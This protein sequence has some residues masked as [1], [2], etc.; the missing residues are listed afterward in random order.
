VYKRYIKRQKSEN[1]DIQDFL[2][3]TRK[4]ISQIDILKFT[5]LSPEDEQI[6][7]LIV[8]ELKKSSSSFCDKAR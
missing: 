5:N 7:K 1:V 6:V 8:A 4:I 2:K 3:A